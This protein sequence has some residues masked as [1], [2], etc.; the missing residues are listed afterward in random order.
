[1]PETHPIYD[2]GFP[3]S[4]WKV[5][6]SVLGLSNGVRELM[7]LIPQADAGRAWQ[8]QSHKTREELYQLGADIFLYAV[9]RKNLR[10]RGD[11]HYVEVNPKVTPKATVAVNRLQFA[12]NWDPEPGGWRRLAAITH[13]VNKATLTVTPVTPG[14]DPIT[15]PVAH[16]TGAGPMKLTA[17]ARAA[18]KKFVDDGGTLVVD[19]AGGSAEFAASVESELA[20]IF[21]AAKPEVLPA[22]HPVYAANGKKIDGFTYRR[23]AREKLVGRTTAPRVQGITVGDKVRVFYSREDLSGGLVGTGIDGILGYE[24]K[25]AVDI[26]SGILAYSAKLPPATQ[27]ATQPAAT[28]ATTKPAGGGG[29]TTKPTTK[30]R[31]TTKKPAATQP[32][33]PATP[34][35]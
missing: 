24:P 33:A 26:M 19:A 25:S 3:R 21:P 15:A 7:I 2:A 32:A 12:G 27:P 22:D 5:K 35:K 16:L 11:T 6:P 31:T 18:I 4:K 28:Q 30:P 29:A 13:N 14:K 8:G 23:I 20:A 1:L 17:E 9:D 34:A 10:Y